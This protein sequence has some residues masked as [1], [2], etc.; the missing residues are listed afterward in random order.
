M[1]DLLLSNSNHLSKRHVISL[2]IDIKFGALPCEKG[3][4]WLHLRH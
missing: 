2:E 4:L 1:A 3:E